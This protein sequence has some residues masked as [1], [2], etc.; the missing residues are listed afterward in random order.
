[1][2]NELLTLVKRV[3][4]IAESGLH[5]TESDWDK[6]RYTDLE[7][8]AMEMM[9]KI[10]DQPLE[11]IALATP[12]H[13]GYKTPKIDVRAVIINEKNEII[14]AFWKEMASNR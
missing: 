13:Y 5:Y 1:M 10:T 12:E 9:S 8:I 7:R 11:V 14:K 3:Q 6:D 4:A 2:K